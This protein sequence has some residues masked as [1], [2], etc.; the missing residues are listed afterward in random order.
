ML[1]IELNRIPAYFQL[2]GNNKR[3]K[4]EALATTSAD[5]LFEMWDS[6]TVTRLL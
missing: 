3:K 1:N 4:S 5:T 6:V 2:S